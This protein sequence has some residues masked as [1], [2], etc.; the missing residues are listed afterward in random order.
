M[1]IG[2]YKQLRV[3]Q[4]GLDLVDFCYDATE[5]FP[6]FQCFELGSQMRRSA[7]SVIANVAEGRGRG[8]DRDYAHFLTI[9]RGSLLENDALLNVAKRR[10]YVSDEQYAKGNE[11]IDHVG[12]M[13]TRMI[14]QLAPPR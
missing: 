13:L 1:W 5:A 10:R 3:C 12:R 6:A 9:S 2:D 7:V 8:T 14:V 11:L 4:R